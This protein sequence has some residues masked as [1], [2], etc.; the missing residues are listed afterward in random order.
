VVL[1]AVETVES[2]VDLSIHKILDKK[3]DVDACVH[4]MDAECMSCTSVALPLND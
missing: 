1:S 3:A 2:K 4:L